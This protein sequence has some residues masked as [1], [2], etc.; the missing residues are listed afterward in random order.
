MAWLDLRG[1]G[2]SVVERLALEELLLR[3]DPVERCWGIVGTHDPTEN[4]VLARG[5]DTFGWEARGDESRGCAIVMGIGGK[6]ERLI[7]VEAAKRDGV[8][9]LK[10]FSGGG[11]VVVDR[12]SL[13]TTFI[14][15]NRELPQVK[16]YPRQ[17][18]EWSAR[19][20]FGPA[21]QRWDDEIGVLVLDK[22]QG[23][24]PLPP[25]EGDTFQLREND[26][27]L[28]DRKIGGNAQSI[29]RGG[30]LH[31]TS[32]LW[33]WHDVNMTY[34]TLPDKR[35]AYRGVRSHDEFLVR[36]KDRYGARSGKDA[37]FEHLK[38]ATGQNFALEKATLEDA[39]VIAEETFGGFQEWFNGK[40]RTRVVQL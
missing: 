35:P 36:L 40:C 27:V 21:F 4:G 34:L 7:D 8:L 14:G 18:M 32:F 22:K 23:R 38:A 1:A 26:Y 37:F 24:K 9:V 33:D 2:L 20:I 19:D 15:R 6:P 25:S 39:L 3:H 13:W 30:F 29:V 28:G 10:R 31:H 16:P 11:T 17:M 12:S 5:L